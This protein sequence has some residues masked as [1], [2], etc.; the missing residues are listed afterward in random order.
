MKVK[1]DGIQNTFLGLLAKIKYCSKLSYWECAFDD[2][3]Q[4]YVLMSSWTSTFFSS[5]SKWMV[6]SWS[7]PHFIHSVLSILRCMQF[8]IQLKFTNLE[9]DLG[10][11]ALS[12]TG[13]HLN[14]VQFWSLFLYVISKCYKQQNKG[15]LV[16][17]FSKNWDHCFFYLNL[18]TFL[19]YGFLGYWK[20]IFQYPPLYLVVVVRPQQK[21]I[22]Q[23]KTNT[24]SHFLLL[25]VVHYVVLWIW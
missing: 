24:Y 23:S 4:Y 15:S 22:I 12:E 18:Q 6:E 17:C 16:S 14:T 9:T 10:Q 5:P 3:S 13:H 1:T 7:I 25:Y 19:V 21:L 20:K 2:H 8:H 11:N